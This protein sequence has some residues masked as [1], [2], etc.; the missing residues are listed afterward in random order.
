MKLSQIILIEKTLDIV[1]LLNKYRTRDDVYISYS[2]IP[3]L[4]INPQSDFKTPIGI[5]A[6][7]LKE[8]WESVENNAVP[9]AGKREYVI[10]FQSTH[11]ILD[12][13]QYTKAMLDSDVDI[14]KKKYLGDYIK[15]Y[16]RFHADHSW[17]NQ[18]RYER[19][20]LDLFFEDGNL[21]EMFKRPGKDGGW[22][23]QKKWIETIF[24]SKHHLSDEDINEFTGASQET[25]NKVRDIVK[26][27]NEGKTISEEKGIT[28]LNHDIANW[29]E[30]ATYPTAAASVFFNITR[31]IASFMASHHN[32]KSQIVWTALLRSL[33]YEGFTDKT[34]MGIIHPNEPTQAVFFSIKPLRLIEI[35]KNKKEPPKTEPTEFYHNKAKEADA[36]VNKLDPDWKTI[37]TALKHGWVAKPKS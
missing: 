2:D 36:S 10:V 34:N 16:S 23:F 27:W 3:K 17:G 33:G 14:I 7:P 6:Y 20:A 13:D 28:Y 35:L 32:R 11:L 29:T 24:F 21:T 4:G 12:V 19:E 5:Y 8:M 22:N 18:V 15:W 26:E 37:A 31:N 30:D 1:S 25:I 9:Y